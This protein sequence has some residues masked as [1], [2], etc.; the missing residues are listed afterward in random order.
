M[1][2]ALGLYE[3]FLS[4]PREGG[5]GVESGL[6]RSICKGPELGV[7]EEYGNYFSFPIVGVG[8]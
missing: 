3:N 1:A 6:G 2:R 8:V 5:Y 7:E 4:T